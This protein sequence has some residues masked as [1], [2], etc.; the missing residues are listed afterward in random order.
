M[1]R[2]GILAG[3]DAVLRRT[4]ASTLDIYTIVSIYPR[5]IKEDKTGSGLD[6]GYFYIAPGSLEH[7]SILHV[8]SSVYWNR[9]SAEMEP[10]EVTV[11]AILMAESIISDWYKGMIGFKDKEAHPGVFFVEGKK[12]VEQIKKDHQQE[13][14]AADILQ[15]RWYENLVIEA[16]SIWARTN[17]NPIAIPTDAKR[18]AEGLGLKNKPWM[19]DFNTLQMVSCINCGNLRNP[20]YPSCPSCRVVVDKDL[21]KKLGLGA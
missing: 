8:G 7:P 11:P 16:D 3:T 13:L 6:P 19:Q 12:T 5:P 18:A 1:S 10:A 15:R 9:Y 20:A 17:G 2:F 21:F 4:P 14:K